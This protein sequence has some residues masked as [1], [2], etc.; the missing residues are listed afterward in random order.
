MEQITNTERLRRALGLAGKEA[1]LLTAMLA[2]TAEAEAL[3]LR[4]GVASGAALRKQMTRLRGKLPRGGVTSCRLPTCYWLSDAAVDA[5]R[6]AL[7]CVPQAGG[8]QQPQGA[9]Q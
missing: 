9:P 1:A 5:C 4:A 8:E 3:R 7:S 6:H 2:G